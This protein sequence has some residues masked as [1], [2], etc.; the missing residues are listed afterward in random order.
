M[1]EA[2]RCHKK[3]YCYVSSVHCFMRACSNS[4]AVGESCGNQRM[5]DTR[6]EEAAAARRQRNSLERLALE[7]VR[8]RRG[9]RT[10]IFRQAARAA[11]RSL[12]K[13][14][15]RFPALRQRSAITAPA[16]S[17]VQ[18]M[19]NWLHSVALGSVALGSLHFAFAEARVVMRELI[20]HINRLVP[21]DEVV[22][23]ADVNC[24]AERGNGGQCANLDNAGG[25]CQLRFMPRG[26][27]IE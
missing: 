25:L 23:M 13:A 22:S 24:L 26:L 8:L 6:K 15:M 2:M 18:N 3:C 10:K 9:Y 1:P 11:W 27:R 5:H 21:R 7:S 12:Q 14:V 19:P 20:W 16:P 4:P 17:S